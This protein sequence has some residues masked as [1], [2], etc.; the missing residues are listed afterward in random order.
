M[1]PAFPVFSNTPSCTTF[2]LRSLDNARAAEGL[3]PFSMPTNWY[4]LT[5]QEQ[6][7]VIVDLERTARGLPP[8][9]GLNRAL[10][11]E[12]QSSAIREV[13]PSMAPRFRVGRARRNVSGMGATLALGY[14]ALEADFVWMYED[15]WGGGASSTPNDACT[16][17]QALGCWGHRDQILGSDNSYNSGVGM[18]CTTCE[19]G[20]GFAMKHGYSSFTT[21]IELPFGRPPRMYFTWAKNVVPFLASTSP[22]Q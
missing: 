6:L 3:P 1:R 18:H 17:P 9:L 20:T 22:H 4:R 10:Y 14:T 19:M 2:V 16:S 8:Y 11:G 5:P 15:G 21:L 7:F 13:D 12:A